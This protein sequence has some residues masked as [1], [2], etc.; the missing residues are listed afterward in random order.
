M[1]SLNFLV[2]RREFRFPPVDAP[3]DLL[4]V[5]GV[6]N[7]MANLEAIVDGE[8]SLALYMTE[9]PLR[10]SQVE[11]QLQKSFGNQ[12]PRVIENRNADDQSGVPLTWTRILIETHREQFR[13]ADDVYHVD[14]DG[15]VVEVPPMVYHLLDVLQE[16]VGKK[17]A[18]EIA[19]QEKK[20]IHI[21]SQ[22]MDGMIQSLTEGR[23]SRKHDIGS[24]DHC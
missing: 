16:G 4:D 18:K 2:P 17:L 5:D 23:Q 9:Q 21:I 19:Q 8:D 14:I 7:F 12:G 24:S 1:T 22:K 13:Q 20:A 11:A 6:Q 15:M 3:W 10:A